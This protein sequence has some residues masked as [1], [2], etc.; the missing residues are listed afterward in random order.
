MFKLKCV[1]SLIFLFVALA[2]AQSQ[3]DLQPSPAALPQFFTA[4]A[5]DESEM[6]YYLSEGVSLDRILSFAWSKAETGYYKGAEFYYNVAS[7]RFPDAYEAQAA[8]GTF[9][10]QI[11]KTSESIMQFQIA[12]N[13][14]VREYDRQAANYFIQR[15]ARES[16]I[17]K[18][19]VDA[20]YLSL[21]HI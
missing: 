7:E 21:I 18:E 19:A 8:L 15:I 5:I 9:Y 1:L 6:D 2:T 10:Y 11:G 20:Y 17:G 16:R 3:S 14:A 12:R 4:P 13:A